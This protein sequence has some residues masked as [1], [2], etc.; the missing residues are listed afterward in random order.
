M[1]RVLI[2]LALVVVLIAVGGLVCVV[3]LGHGN[4]DSRPTGRPVETGRPTGEAARPAVP[5]R[6]AEEKTSVPD[7]LL[8]AADAPVDQVGVAAGAEE[9]STAEAAAETGEEVTTADVKSRIGALLDSLSEEESRELLRQAQARQMRQWRERARY[10]LPSDGRLQ[11]LRW[12]RAENLK[13]NEAQEQKITEFQ[14]IMRSRTDEA[15][16]GVWA[17]EDELRERASALAAE[18]RTDEVRTI[19]GEIGRLHQETAEIKGQ[20]DGEY[21]QLLRGLLT[22][23]QMSVVERGRYSPVGA[24]QPW[25]GVPKR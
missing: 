7:S 22:P 15:L 18:G 1:Y 16:Q 11:M 4:S 9:P 14:E 6:A 12:G 8:G 23:D 17:Q 10:L 2:G 20:L 19:H 3:F 13:L 24:G 5:A 21:K 25:G